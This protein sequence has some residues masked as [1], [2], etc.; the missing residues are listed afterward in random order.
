MHCPYL[1]CADIL[2]LIRC[3][4]PDFWDTSIDLNQLKIASWE[5]P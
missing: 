5:Y 4:P 2:H 3:L 1:F